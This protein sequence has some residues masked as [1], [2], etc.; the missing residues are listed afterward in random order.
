MMTEQPTEADLL[1]MALHEKINANPDLQIL[2]VIGGWLYN[3]TSIDD[4]GNG[5]VIS[6]AFVPEGK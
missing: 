5:Q 4:H 1:A 2:K 6:S 3:F